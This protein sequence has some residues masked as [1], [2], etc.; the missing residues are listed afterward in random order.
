[1]KGLGFLDYAVITLYLLATGIF[2]SSF[3]KRRRAPHASIFSGGRAMSWVP[4]GSPSSPPI[5]ARLP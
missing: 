4:W 3:Y 1:M 5:S 2:G